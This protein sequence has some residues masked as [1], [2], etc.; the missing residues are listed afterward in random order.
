M[1]TR[2]PWGKNIV[3]NIN[4]KY[5]GK[6]KIVAPVRFINGRTVNLEQMKINIYPL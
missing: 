4:Y 3:D 2:T 5:F 6:Y 1:P